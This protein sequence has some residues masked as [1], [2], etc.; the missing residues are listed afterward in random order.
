MQ[1]TRINCVD[2]QVPSRIRSIRILVEISAFAQQFQ[3]RLYEPQVFSG[4]TCRS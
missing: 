1:L 3:P 4:P 2:T